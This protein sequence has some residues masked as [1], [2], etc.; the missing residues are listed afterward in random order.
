MTTSA[1][2]PYPY[3]RVLR[4]SEHTFLS[5]LVWACDCS[6][7]DGS[8]SKLPLFDVH[9]ETENDQIAQRVSLKDLLRTPARN[10]A[11]KEY[12]LGIVCNIWTNSIYNAPEMS[13]STSCHS[14]FSHEGLEG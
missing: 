13:I 4:W 1:T 2:T 9:L 6:T 10:N 3:H 8:L 11:G 5:A 7:D 12:L 14:W